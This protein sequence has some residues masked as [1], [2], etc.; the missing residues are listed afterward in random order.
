MSYKRRGIRLPTP[1]RSI[2]TIATLL[3]S[4]FAV[5]CSSTSK[6]FIISG[7][8]VACEEKTAQIQKEYGANDLASACKPLCKYEAFGGISHDII[9]IGEL[10]NILGECLEKGICEKVGPPEAT[11]KLTSKIAPERYFLAARCGSEKARQN[12]LRLNL[13]L[14]KPDESLNCSQGMVFAMDQGDAW[15]QGVGALL[16]LPVVIPLTLLAPLAALL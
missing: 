12:L 4:S 6:Q 8:E 10:H 1:H 5:A 16:L 14:P 7:T 9:W 13:A 11:S 2:R 3:L 15:W